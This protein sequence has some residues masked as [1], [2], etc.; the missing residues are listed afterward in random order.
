MKQNSLKKE[1]ISNVNPTLPQVW[2]RKLASR[3]MWSRLEAA[4]D[5]ATSAQLGH[6]G[7]KELNMDLEMKKGYLHKTNNQLVFSIALIV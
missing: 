4:L 1:G 2:R 6:F 3:S 5:S 7:E